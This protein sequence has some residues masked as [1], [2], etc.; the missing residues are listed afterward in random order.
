MKKASDYRKHAEECRALAKGMK[1][2]EQRE[3]LLAMAQ[4]WERLADQ[5]DITSRNEAEMA[6]Q[7][8]P[9]PQQPEQ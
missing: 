9:R 6:S 3:Q 7:Q 2:A 4:T 8:R 1:Q 5:R